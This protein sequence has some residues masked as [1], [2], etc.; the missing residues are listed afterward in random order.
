MT[1]VLAPNI[2]LTVEPRTI[3]AHRRVADCS[4]LPLGQVA[5][6]VPFRDWRFDM[7]LRHPDLWHDGK[8]TE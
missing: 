8:W 2:H 6:A 5:A 4:D 3:L 7:E 1:R